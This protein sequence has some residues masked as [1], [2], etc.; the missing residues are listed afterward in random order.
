[1]FDGDHGDNSGRRHTAFGHTVEDLDIVVVEP[2]R[3]MQTLM[4]S[5]LHGLRARGCGSTTPPAKR[6]AT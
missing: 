2:S 6:C 4:R 3:A 1:M 5:M